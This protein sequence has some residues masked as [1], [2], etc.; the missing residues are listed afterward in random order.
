MILGHGFFHSSIFGSTFEKHVVAESP[1]SVG[2]QDLNGVR[3]C[4]VAS[5]F[6]LSS[7]G[8]S[9][10]QTFR[11]TAGSHMMDESKAIAKEL[12]NDNNKRLQCQSVG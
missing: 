9:E 1:Y 3:V 5:E 6:K 12:T 8:G 10:R 2:F 7:D 4:L 11:G